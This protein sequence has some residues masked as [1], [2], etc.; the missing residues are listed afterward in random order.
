MLGGREFW[1]GFRRLPPLSAAVAP[2][3]EPE[4]RTADV[5]SEE[6]LAPPSETMVHA[7]RLGVVVADSAFDG[8]VSLRVKPTSSPEPE[9]GAP[10]DRGGVV[11]ASAAEDDGEAEAPF[12]AVP[13]ADEPPTPWPE[14]GDGEREP[15]DSREEL[16]G[17]RMEEPPVAVAFLWPPP[18]ETTSLC[19]SSPPASGES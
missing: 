11:D 10:V 1:A 13:A 17:P 12:G 16:M 18:G 14:A 2:E 4:V 15:V 7:P 5:G 8:R 3:E 9:P 6:P 19:N